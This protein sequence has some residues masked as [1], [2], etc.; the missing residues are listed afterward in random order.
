MYNTAVGEKIEGG[1]FTIEERSG[2]FAAAGVSMV[3]DTLT[4]QTV[5]SIGKWG[6]NSGSNILRE[7][8]TN[9]GDDAARGVVKSGGDDV[10]ANARRLGFEGEN[11]VGITGPK[12]KIFFSD[13]HYRIP[14]R[15]IKKA[16][17]L[18]E[19]K[20]VN[21]LSFTSQLKDF[22][23]FSQDNG[24]SMIIYTRSNTLFSQPLQL[25]IDNGSIIRKIIPGK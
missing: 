9:T 25:L 17:T 15:L 24:H 14:D 18:E 7:T 12:E 22:Y 19:V 20:N 2:Q 6:I 4:I 3:V 5:V 1:T 13:G 11:A 23:Q 8:L 10:M 21:H 16:K